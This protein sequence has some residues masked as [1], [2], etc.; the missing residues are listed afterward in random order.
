[1]N[2]SFW[3]KFIVLIIAQA[4]LCTYFTF[5]HLVLLFFVPVLFLCLP[6]TTS[7]PKALIIAFVT[8]LTIDFLSSGSIG[9]TSAALLVC[10]LARKGIISIS[11]GRE[12][13]YRSERLSFHRQGGM[14]MG[15]A[16]FLIVATFLLIY[17]ILDSS[18]TRTFGFN[19]AKFAL[20]L[21]CDFLLSFV[22]AVFLCSDR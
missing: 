20:S 19:V 22:V 5:S 21:L 17:I 2:R 16:V 13:L 18:G 8:G 9:I 11:F 4:L 15:V 7:T 14:K 6:L 1:M 12:T 3:L 10:A